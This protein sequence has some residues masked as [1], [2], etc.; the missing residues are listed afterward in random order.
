MNVESK[1]LLMDIWF[2]QDIEP[3]C[4]KICNIVDQN[5]T[6]VERVTHNFKPYGRTIV[7]I[8][9][10]SHFTIHTYP[11][12]QYVTL[13]IYI[14]NPSYDLEKVKDQILALGETICYNTSIRPR[15]ICVDSP[16]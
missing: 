9:S 2:T 7:Y 14:C 5:F 11:E 13:D 1:H 8:L 6:V 4:D 16:Q 12:H 15:G 3:L 10:E